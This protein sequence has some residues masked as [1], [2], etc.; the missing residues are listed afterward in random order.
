MSVGISAQNLVA[1]YGPTIVLDGLSFAA[2]A[3][4]TLAVLGRNGVGKTT[5]L[6]TLMGLTNLSDGAIQLGER[7][8]ATLPTHERVR[9]GLCYVPQ[10]RRIFPSL[11]V[12]ENLAVSVIPGG[13]T[14]EAVFD[15]FPGLA[16]RRNNA[17][18]QLSGGE[19]QMLAVG[20][21]L[22]G[23]PDV[24]LLDEPMEGLAPIIVE[25]LFDALGR[26]RKESGMTMLL[27][28]Q[29]VDLAIDFAQDAIVLDRGKV[30]WKGTTAALKA[31]EEAQHNYL[32][33]GV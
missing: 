1:G 10:E 18:N 2:P 3:G 31:D 14:P 8:I 20:R 22:V 32:S 29:K 11:T 30:V 17:G 26:I 24:L 5:L 28:E 19:Q 7:G 21:A 27:V 15:L 12:A 16:A 9:S 6:C 23:K 13:W 25:S 4:S 33:V